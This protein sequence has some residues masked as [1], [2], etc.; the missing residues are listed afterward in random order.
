[1]FVSVRNCFGILILYC[2]FG[3]LGS[4]VVEFVCYVMCFGKICVVSKDCVVE[5][6]VVVV[7]EKGSG[8]INIGSG[9]CFF[10]YDMFFLGDVK[11]II[12][13]SG[14]NFGYVGIRMEVRMNFIF[15]CCLIVEVFGICL[16]VVIVVGLGIMVEWL[17]QDVVLV[18][19]GNILFMGVILVVLIM[20]LGLIFGVYFNLVVMM[21]FCMCC[22][23]FVVIVGGY[24]V[25]QIVGGVFGI[26]IVYGMFDV[27]FF[28]VV[29]KV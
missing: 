6:Y 15:V 10:V 9:I 7:F 2:V 17:M 23:I 4:G 1:M 21:V 13:G 28:Q 26:V 5:C 11:G 18:L 12:F 25:V 27:L 3:R 14:E 24:I 8:I 16:F 19:L 29:E 22:D 20:I